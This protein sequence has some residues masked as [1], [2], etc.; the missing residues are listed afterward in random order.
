MFAESIKL[1]DL[2]RAMF[3]AHPAYLAA[4]G[5]SAVGTMPGISM[6][7]ELELLVRLGMTPRQALAAATSNYSTR[8]GWTE[9]GLIETGRRAD[10]L[11]LSADPTVDIANTRRISGVMLAGS[12]LDRAALLK[13]RR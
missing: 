10:I 8:F 13:D 6:H 5:A 4:S 12:M 1:F 11:L 3:A 2:N 7:T 9:L